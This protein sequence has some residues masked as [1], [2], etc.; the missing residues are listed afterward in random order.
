MLSEKQK[1]RFTAEGADLQQFVHSQDRV[2]I[3]EM[4]GDPCVFYRI[5]YHH[6]RTT[7]VENI[8]DLHMTDRAIQI[9]PVSFEAV[10]NLDENYP[11]TKPEIHIG[12]ALDERGKI[13]HLY[14]SHILF[15]VICLFSHWRVGYSLVDVVQRIWNVVT[16]NHGLLNLDRKDCINI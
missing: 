10:I 5:G 14:N 15:F 4:R 9:M 12:P 13:H 2:G 6:L 8:H 7:V 1:N 11:N 3:L 16:Y